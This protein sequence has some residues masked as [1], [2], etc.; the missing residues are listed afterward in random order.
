MNMQL[1]GNRTKKSAFRTFY[2]L[3]LAV[4]FLATIICVCGLTR[5]LYIRG[6]GRAYYAALS[7]K[8]GI[9][10]EASDLASASGA[11]D[12]GSETLRAPDAG[13]GTWTPYTDFDA[14]RETNPGLV[15]WIRCEGTNID[16]PVVQGTDNEYYLTR[17]PD[18]TTNKMGSIFLDFRCS[19]DFSGKNSAIYGHH[20]K[21]GDMFAALEN[22]REQAFYDEHPVVM[23][24]TSERDYLMEVFAGYVVNAEW[25]TL[26]LDFDSTAGFELYVSGVRRRSVFESGADISASDR[27]ITLS[28]CTYDFSEA[29]FVLVGK[30]VELQNFE[31]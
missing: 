29:R 26:P 12:G 5:E 10:P 28:T 17:L 21:S 6:Q 15:A 16:Y 18:G 14:L 7:S 27:L 30:L 9:N 8:T 25:E 23:L 31:D 4:C 24:Y 20:M 1:I 19:P 2:P 11:R 3:L 13:S 22:Y